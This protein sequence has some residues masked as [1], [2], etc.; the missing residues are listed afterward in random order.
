MKTNQKHTSGKIINWKIQ[1]LSQKGNRGSLS[2]F[3]GKLISDAQ[4]HSM[5]WP[6][7][8]NHVRYTYAVLI[9]LV[10]VKLEVSDTKKMRNLDPK[11]RPPWLLSRFIALKN[12]TKP[13]KTTSGLVHEWSRT[14]APPIDCSI[15]GGFFC[16]P[17]PE[18]KIAGWSLA[19]ICLDSP[20]RKWSEWNGWRLRKWFLW[21]VHHAVEGLCPN[22]VMVQY[23]AKAHFSWKVERA[24]EWTKQGASC[25]SKNLTANL[26]PSQES[27]TSRFSGTVAHLVL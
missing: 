11:W 24:H 8:H 18:K 25:K 10:S 27:S 17:R 9:K 13:S 22:T 2:R 5:L 4:H 21:I 7:H 3:G 23:G 15:I 1:A 6:Y 20:C 12:I 19:R 14:T 26:F 16:G